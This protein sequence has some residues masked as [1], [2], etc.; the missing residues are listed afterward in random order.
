MAGATR[1]A[2][3]ALERLP[4]RISIGLLARTFTN[5]LLDEVIDAAGVREVRLRLLPARLMLMF[6][7][8]CWLFP[9]SGYGSVMARLADAHAAAGPDWATWTVPTT[10]PIS[11]AKARLG[12]EPVELLFRRVAGSTGRPDTAGNW[13]RGLRVVVADAFEL[14]LPGPAEGAAAPDSGAAACNPYPAH[15]PER[16]GVPAFTQ[17]ALGRP[18]L[19]SVL[20]DWGTGALL[21]GAPG[22]LGTGEPAPTGGLLPA[23]GPGM[24]VLTGDAPG[25]DNPGE[26]NPTGGGHPWHAWRALAATG[27]HG[28]WRV[29]AAL[30]LP[31]RVALPDGSYLSELPAPAGAS[32]PP[33][34]LRVVEC[35][36]TAG[37]GRLL[38]ATTVLDAGTAPVADLA[39]LHRH[40]WRAETL[41]GAFA[42]ARHDP[43][44]SVAGHG[45]AGHGGPGNGGP[46]VQ[47]RSGVPAMISQEF[48]ALLCVHQA[49]R[50][51]LPSSSP[52]HRS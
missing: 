10:G 5:K 30:A 2:R 4:D 45:V 12:P 34:A 46:R 36:P 28:C 9:R 25:G 47:L 35:G 17:Q 6:T 43:G 50:E 39:R 49:I 22:P 27:A 42:T 15:A 1:E 26:D 7:L 38:L 44:P 8:A 23:L 29:P 11:R 40:R 16:V 33:L 41:A 21:A 52:T 48:W 32:G 51:V 24:L 37:C 20:V 13:L 31:M 18:H 14:D 3:Q 19:A